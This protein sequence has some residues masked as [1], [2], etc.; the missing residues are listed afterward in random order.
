[1]RT[2]L[3]LLL[4]TATFCFALGATL[5]LL[6]VSRL[7]LLDEEPSLVEIVSSLWRDGEWALAA[8]I[9]LFSLA[10]PAAKLV[11]LHIL[12]LGGGAHALHRAMGVISK[13]SMLDVLLVAVVIFAAKTSGLASATTKPGLWFFATSAILT[14]LAS[15]LG[16]R[17]ENEEAGFPEETPPAGS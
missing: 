3:A 15:V 17:I 7:W 2:V 12:A 14:A 4:V 8:V 6:A 9:G 1:M 5:P 16:G 11:Y 13:W 10:L